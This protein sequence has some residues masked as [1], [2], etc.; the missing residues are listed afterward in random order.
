MVFDIIFFFGNI[1]FGDRTWEEHG[2]WHGGA[3]ARGCISW[4]I[5]DTP[6]WHLYQ[7]LAM[8]SH[9]ICDL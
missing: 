4:V 7:G 6:R 1:A 2:L 5:A 3:V 9:P 8:Y